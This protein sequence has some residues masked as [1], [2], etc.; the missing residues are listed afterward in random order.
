MTL[1]F[2]RLVTGEDIV[3]EASLVDNDEENVHYIIHDPMKVMYMMSERGLGISLA[4]WIIPTL[5]KSK[6]YKI[7]T[8]DI[9]V[10]TET[11]NELIMSY[12]KV[13]AQYQRQE[14]EQE[15]GEEGKDLLL[16]LMEERKKKKKSSK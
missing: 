6:V 13:Q 8:S 16:N 10:D 5:T 2:F 1:K 3:G 14:N 11:S 7:Y 15:L 4:P 12:H 9:L